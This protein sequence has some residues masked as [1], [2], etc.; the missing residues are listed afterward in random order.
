MK[1]TVVLSP[2]CTAPLVK[3]GRNGISGIVCAKCRQVPEFK[4]PKRIIPEDCFNVQVL[5]D[6]M[7]KYARAKRIHDQERDSYQ[8]YSWGY[9]GHQH[10]EDME[11]CGRDFMKVL[12]DYIDNRVVIRLQERGVVIQ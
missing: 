11:N 5:L 6:A 3:Q 7:D 1:K 9:Y 12:N 10:V 8:G 4:H 2:C